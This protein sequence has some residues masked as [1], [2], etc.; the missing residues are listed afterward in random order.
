MLN[1]EEHVA[2]GNEFIKTVSAEIGHSENPG[3]SLILFRAVLHTLR[4]IIPVAESLQLL[5]QL[6]SFLKLIYVDSWKYR[7]EPAKIYT[8]EDFANEVELKQT[9]Y[10]E[11]DFNFGENTRELSI[12]VMNTL[13]RYVDPGE[14]EDIL[15][16]LSGEL[17]NYF[18]VTKNAHPNT[19][20][21]ELPDDYPVDR[22]PISGDIKLKRK[23]GE[24]EG[25]E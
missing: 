1:F 7:P 3:S 23:S 16:N 10:G 17:R 9:Q 24:R 22:F 5:A 14:Y 21:K 18:A 20:G 8:I 15:A 12:Y 2:K 4:D 13:R 25:S 19:M 6:P 11:K